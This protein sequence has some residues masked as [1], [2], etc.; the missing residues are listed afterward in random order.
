[1]F[2]T[3]IYPLYLIIIVKA[4]AEAGL[5]SHETVIFSVGL[6]NE[7]AAIALFPAGRERKFLSRY[8]LLM[9]LDFCANQIYCLYS[10]HSPETKITSLVC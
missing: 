10:A 5:W 8:V 7:V 1:M 6:A 9:G 2:Y 3:F 4:V